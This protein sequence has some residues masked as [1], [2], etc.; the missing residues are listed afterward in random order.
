[1]I[2]V[3]RCGFSETLES[4]AALENRRLSPSSLQ[5][6]TAYG[7]CWFAQ[8]GILRA[9]A[10]SG[11]KLVWDAFS[12]P[13]GKPLEVEADF[14]ADKSQGGNIGVIGYVTRPG[15]GADNFCGYEFALFLQQQY[16][17]IGRHENNF[18]S[19]ATQKVTN[20]QDKTWVKLS[21]RIE[22]VEKG[23]KL[24]LSLD[25]Q[26]ILEAFDDQPLKS[27]KVGFRPWQ[28]TVEYRNLKIN[29]QA[30]PLIAATEEQE[31]LPW[32]ESLDTRDLPPI[33]TVCRSILSR[34]NSVGLDFWQSQP[35][36][37]GCSLKILYPAEPKREVQTIFDD[38]KG[39]IYDANLSNDA[40]SVFFSYRPESESYWSLY[41]IG[42]DGTGLKRLTQ[43]PYFDVSP[44]QTPDGDI[45]FVS[46]RRFGHTV[47]QPG[48]SSNLFRMNP[49]GSDIECVSMNTLS[50]F[51]PQMLPDGRVLFTRWEYIDRDL[52]YRQ[53]LW[54][55]NPDGTGYQLYFGNT[56]RNCGSF[57]QSRPIPGRSDEVV[58]TFT[59]HHGYPHGA[60]G[61]VRRNRG[62]ETDLNVSYEYITKEFGENIGDRS[63]KMAYRDPYPLSENRFLCSF[64][65]ERNGEEKY[66]IYLLNRQGQKRL[67]YEDSRTGMSCLCP[68]AVVPQQFYQSASQ[69]LETSSAAGTNESRPVGTALLTDVYRGLEPYVKRGQVKS[70]RIMEQVRKSVDL[71]RR[72]YD[73]SPV[74]SYGT[75]YAKRCWGEVP[76]ESDGSAY[77]EVPA[78]REIY[79]Q[80]LDDQGRELQRMT[81]ALQLMPNQRQS[82]VGCHE[83]RTSTPTNRPDQRQ[84]MAASRQ[85]SVPRMP[86]WWSK[87]PQINSLP[88]KNILFYPTLVQ[89]VLD[90]YCVSCHSGTNPAGGCD[91]TGGKTRFFSMS[92]DNLLG[93]TKS[94]RE[95]NMQTGRIL[96]EEAAKGKPMVQYYW[97]LYTPTG[98]NQPLEAGA[99]ASRLTDYIES[100]DHAGRPIPLEARQ[101]I[102]LWLDSNACYY[103]TYAVCRPYSGGKRDL[104]SE[105]DGERLAGWFQKDFMSVYNRRCNGCHGEF[106]ANLTI[107]A[108]S[109]PT[110]NWEGRF[111]WINLSQP[112]LSPALTV[113]LAQPFGRGIPVNSEKSKSGKDLV[114]TE[115]VGIAVAGTKTVKCSA[116][117]QDKSEFLFA[118]PADA[119]YQIILEAIQKGKRA[120]LAQPRADMPG[121]ANQQ[122]EP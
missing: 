70:I 111:A 3:S 15:E 112:E 34:P 118:S 32:P 10:G 42:L 25:G 7:G 52:T 76:V 115:T 6:F 21:F 36:G 57:L 101:R 97:L 5:G 9:P 14:Y 78:L 20:V 55:Q 72:A 92:Y 119:D 41:K 83:S 26:L 1:M 51:N 80:I 54:T 116:D 16:A 64:G 46:S 60:I 30:I 23:L 106:A 105:G 87:V 107:Q 19:L 47:C 24:R 50:D 74:M 45:I 113:H 121:F 65:S 44:C 49:D 67:L 75:Y 73:Q 71:N 11:P 12:N 66:R 31:I 53:S 104:F 79:L 103:N 59:P 28:R 122:E 29:G 84:P 38:P 40:R 94:Y 95:H 82:C 27:G 77:F 4:F 86:N 108:N 37:L 102:Y 114:G 96:P 120:M 117:V 81:S 68:L 22:P 91:L 69:L 90:E 100:P 61:L 58:S 110:T 2:T 43:G 98:V 35:E 93:R 109:T 33:L 8:A 85:P 18:R 17:M 48:P 63:R 99:H 56:V 13:D 39:C 62:P 89:P 88:D